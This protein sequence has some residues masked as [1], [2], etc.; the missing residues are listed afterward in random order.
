MRFLDYSRASVAETISHCY[1]ALDQAYI[2]GA[3]MEAV[4]EQANIVWKK[5]NNFITYLNRTV[6]KGVKKADQCGIITNKTN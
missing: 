6:K 4:K 2:N 5:V 3:E 1:V